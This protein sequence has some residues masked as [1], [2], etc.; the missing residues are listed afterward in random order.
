MTALSKVPHWKRTRKL[1]LER[2]GYVCQLQYPGCTGE[3]T[4]ADHIQPR[5]HGG[6]NDPANLRAAC[7]TCNLRRGDGTRPPDPVVSAW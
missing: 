3:A 5:R 2:D 4:H 6:T 1:V 7:A